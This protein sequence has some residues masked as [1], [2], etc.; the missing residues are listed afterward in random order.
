[1]S[2]DPKLIAKLQKLL[3]VSDKIKMDQM[4]NILKVDKETFNEN[5]IDW[6]EEFRFRIDGDY[7]IVNQESVDD[8]IDE[9]D[10]KFAV[11]E[12]QE[13]AGIGKVDKDLGDFMD[14]LDASYDLW[15]KQAKEG[16]GKIESRAIKLPSAPKPPPAL[17]L[18]SAPKP[19]PAPK[20]PGKR[21]P[22]IKSKPIEEEVEEPLTEVYS[23][24]GGGEP[25]L[26]IF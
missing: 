15:D 20:P 5:I 23:T 10:S 3:K 12:K 25:F 8:F 16:V 2:I 9:L 26:S 22:T 18:P 1:M 6:A 19:P 4:R 24:G 14:A 13:I 7:V 17:K 21:P 11:W